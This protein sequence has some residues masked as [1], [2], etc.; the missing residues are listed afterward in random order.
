M[1]VH[2]PE[3]GAIKPRFIARKQRDGAEVLASLGMT[4]GGMIFSVIPN[5]V[6][7][8]PAVSGCKELSRERR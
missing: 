7:R 6:P 2:R 4:E 5:P 1:A 3:S 8:L